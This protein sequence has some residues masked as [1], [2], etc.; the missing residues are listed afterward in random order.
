MSDTTLVCLLRAAAAQSAVSDLKQAGVPAP[1][2]S[3]IDGAFTEASLTSL[4][5]AKRDLEHL[6]EGIRNGGIVVAVETDARYEE[7][8]Q[9]VFERYQVESESAEQVEAH[10]AAVPFTEASTAGKHTVDHGNIRTYRRVVEI[11]AARADNPPDGEQIIELTETA[12]E[13]VLDKHARVME[14]IHISKTATERTERIHETVRRTE[15]DVKV[16]DAAGSGLEIQR[17]S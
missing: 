9:R 5:I 12:E 6:R 4:D 1:S 14:E 8:I 3:V 17:E 2:I 13:L 7:A 11:P 16:L 10:A 15:V